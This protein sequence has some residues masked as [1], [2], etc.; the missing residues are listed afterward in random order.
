MV[1][2]S[3]NWDL[4]IKNK[5]YKELS[6][7]PLEERGRITKIIDNLP[8]NPYIGDVEKI[9]DEENMWRRRVGNYRIF[10]E[11]ISRE[12]I[13]YIFHIERRTSSTY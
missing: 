13:I 7:L 6:K 5:V 4:R 10:Y 11:I 2:S 12:R 3:I 8:H 1:N 9:K